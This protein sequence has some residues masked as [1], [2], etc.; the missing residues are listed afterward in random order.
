MERAGHV[1]N[2]SEGSMSLKIACI[3][4]HNFLSSLINPKSIVLDIGANHGDFAHTMIQ[5]YHCRVFAAEPVEKLSRSIPRHS[6][7]TLFPVALGG[8][9]RSISM[10]VFAERCAS[11]L[12]SVRPDEKLTAHPVEMITL[13]ELRRR[14]HAE[15]VDILKLDIEGSEIDVFNACSDEEL[16]SIMQITVEFH[17][18][19]YP[20]LRTSVY[21]LRERM[22]RIGFWVLPFSLDNSNV[23]FINR[24]TGV[25]Q[26]EFGYLGTIVKYREGILRRLGLRDRETGAFTSV[27]R[28]VC[29]VR[30][31]LR[32][33]VIKLKASPV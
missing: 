22:R 14:V 6:L 11:L 26:I 16:Q 1:L 23:L 20:E 7:L 15:R 25:N 3:C 9:N 33:K 4:N 13:A 32:S 10:N 19:L 17:D 29:N 21:R 28:H 27:V 2:H 12:G 8:E 30:S 24:Q 31:S 5:R 18:F